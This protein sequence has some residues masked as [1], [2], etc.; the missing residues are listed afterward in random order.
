MPDFTPVSDFLQAGDQPKRIDRSAE[1]RAGDQRSETAPAFREA[2]FSFAVA[3][4][5][6]SI[7]G[8]SVGSHLDRWR[9]HIVNNL[10]EQGIVFSQTA[11]P[12]DCLRTFVRMHLAGPCRLECEFKLRARTHV[13]DLDRMMSFTIA[14]FRTE[15]TPDAQH[16]EHALGARPWFYYD[17]L[18][19]PHQMSVW[20]SKACRHDGQA[21]DFTRFHLRRIPYS[22]CWADA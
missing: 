2:E 21:Q 10:E 8:G 5:C 16:I 22:E 4:R 3:E 6:P 11:E 15:V 14:C 7:Q 20:Q 19:L 1:G 9:R 18:A 13:T 12:V 17:N